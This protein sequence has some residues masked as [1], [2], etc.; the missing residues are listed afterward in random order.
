M[1]AHPK[2]AIRK[3]RH[4]FQLVFMDV[5]G[6]TTPETLGGYTN[7]SKSPHV[8]NPH[9]PSVTESGNGILI[10]MLLCLLPPPLQ[11]SPMQLWGHG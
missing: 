9:T 2:S 11:E 10:E 5:M 6:R 4:I 1:L 3:V 8:Y 7:D